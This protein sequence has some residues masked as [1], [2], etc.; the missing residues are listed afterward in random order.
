MLEVF[1]GQEVRFLAHNDDAKWVPLADIRKA[2]GITTTHASKVVKRIKSTFPGCSMTSTM[3][4]LGETDPLRRNNEVILLNREGVV[5]FFHMINVA[6][7]Q[8]PHVRLNCIEF[9]RWVARFIGDILSGEQ[10]VLSSPV[11][12]AHNI[13]AAVYHEQLKIGKSMTRDHFIGPEQMHVI[14]LKKAEVDSGVDLSCWYSIIPQEHQFYETL[15]ATEI[16][17]RLQ[18]PLRAQEVNKRLEAHG[19]VRRHGDGV[20][21]ITP[22]GSEYGRAVPV[23]KSLPALIASERN[24]IV[25]QPR[26]DHSIVQVLQ[27][28]INPNVPLLE[29]PKPL[30]T[31]V[32]TISV[33]G[34][35]IRFMGGWVSTYDMMKASGFTNSNMQKVLTTMCKSYPKLIRE[36]TLADLGEK[37]YDKGTREEVL[38]NKHGVKV[39]FELLP[40]SSIP[41]VNEQTNHVKN[42]V[43]SKAAN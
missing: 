3:D 7:I 11:V 25:R 17:E 40:Q 32:E 26:W 22:K 5:H 30:H 27:N 24:P 41:V 1:N 34:L 15:N 13:A 16:G 35:S 18:P 14:A 38:L 6:K 21:E 29:E 9:Q 33:D 2:I 12:T 19:Y 31:A 10:V 42:F 39:F 4:L 8:D 37:D 36:V 28:L 43:L 23:H 20:W